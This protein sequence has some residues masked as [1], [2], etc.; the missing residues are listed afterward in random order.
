MG[1]LTFQDII[2]FGTTDVSDRLLGGRLAYGGDPFS[3]QIYLSDGLLTMDNRDGGLDSTNDTTCS[4]ARPR[5]GTDTVDYTW[6]QGRARE[7]LTPQNRDTRGRKV[8]ALTGLLETAIGLSRETTFEMSADDAADIE[9][10]DLEDLV[11]GLVTKMMLAG[12]FA[13][14]DIILAV[15]VVD[16]GTITISPAV[17]MRNTDWLRTIADITHTR[18]MDVH[19]ERFVISRGAENPNNVT[20]NSPVLENGTVL[21]E[22]VQRS[23][24]EATIRN[25]FENS[26]FENN[27]PASVAKYGERAVRLPDWLPTTYSAAN[28]I[29]NAADPGVVITVV[30]PRWQRDLAG[31]YKLEEMEVGE[32]VHV[33]L[34]DH[35]TT[36]IDDYGVVT[37]HTHVW[38]EDRA[39]APRV[40]L[41][42]CVYRHSETTDTWTLGTSRLGIDTILN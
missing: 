17:T 18:P 12:G 29:L 25:S 19:G 3:G 40:T 39:Q 7:Q 38:P 14:R 22:S 15:D 35:T 11:E 10:G 2:S 26:T 21:V 42:I 37:R 31:L 5:M 1:L 34:H 8:Y 30:C 6:W 27:V 4:I 32:T 33:S 36:L 23:E 20:V 16:V 13:Q 24:E 41:E 28:L 9:A